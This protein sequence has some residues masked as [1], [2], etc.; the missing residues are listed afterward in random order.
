M[1]YNNK[2]FKKG[3]SLIVLV[4]TIIV[5]II[6]AAA[7][8]LTLTGNNPIENVKKAIFLNDTDTFKNELEMY[9]SK[10]YAQNLGDYDLTKADFNILSGNL[11]TAIPSLENK[12][13]YLNEFEV[14]DG[15]LIYIG[16]KISEK[17]WLKTI[18][19]NIKYDV[20]SPILANGMTPIKWDDNG[21][22]IETTTEDIDWYNYENKKW[23]NAKTSDGS[24]WVWIP[25]YEYK[26]PSENEHTINAGTI[27][28]NFLSNT[29]KNATKD[30][31]VHPAFTFGTD[32]LMGIWIAKFE[33]SGNETEVNIKPNE[34]SLRN[35]KVGQMFT[36]SKNMEKNSIY[37]WGITGIGIDTHLMKNV[38]W[39]AVAYLSQSIYG[40]NREVWP[41]PNVNYITGQSGN[42]E[43][44]SELTTTYSYNNKEYG[45]EAS[46]TGNFY[47]IYD[48]SGGTWEYVAA[49]VDNGHQ[50]LA[51]FGSS[52]IGNAIDE[53]YKDIYFSN[54]NTKLANYAVNNL[55]KGDAVYETSY[56][57]NENIYDRSWFLDYSYMP[58]SN[59]PFFI[60]GGNNNSGSNA[61]IFAFHSHYGSESNIYGFRP[62]LI[63]K[64]SL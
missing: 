17:N 60:R 59:T 22:E 40:K 52:F 2:K 10:M 14:I 50:Y 54:G 28:T 41:N 31:I 39:G 36:A 42:N 3:I 5:M 32:E 21:N 20:N 30:Y 63:V 1:K 29:Q 62:T 45:V 15:Q 49:Y 18:N 46:T 58:C 43:Y 47:G 51:E 35:L 25:R 27:E 61:G 11:Y 6:L 37:G 4:I 8:I 26:I 34:I 56:L 9:K 16:D 13:K 12:K 23:A 48:M 57:D 44:S 19:I 55:K 7:I 38:E 64:D 24:M 33:A 53:K